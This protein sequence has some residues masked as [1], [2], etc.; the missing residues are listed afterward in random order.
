VESNDTAESGQ[1]GPGDYIAIEVVD[2][3]VGIPDAIIGRVFD[4]FF[5]TKEHGK[6]SGLGLSMVV[7]FIEQSGG[8]VTVRSQPDIGTTFALHLPRSMG[9]AR[10]MLRAGLTSNGPS[11]LAHWRLC[12]SS[13]TTINCG[14]RQ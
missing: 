5:T 9:H 7:G 1:L 8:Q 10:A 4:P 11:E 14:V 3:G 6:G 2:T 13:K 12:W